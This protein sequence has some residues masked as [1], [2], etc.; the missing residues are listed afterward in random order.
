MKNIIIGITVAT[1][2]LG[3]CNSSSNKTGDNKVSTDTTKTQQQTDS[4][5]TKDT[6]S[7]K[8]I[9]SGYMQLK[10]ALAN[11]NGND[12]ANGGKAILDAVAK[13]D[14]SSLS[15]QQKKVYEDV[16]DDIKDNPEHIRENSGKIAHQRQHFDMLSQDMYDLVKA[17]GTGQILYNDYCAMYNNA[18]GAT[19]LSETKEIKN[20]YLG[21]KMPTCGE[22]KE[23]IK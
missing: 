5:Q 20:P 11:D 19:W 8:E 2:S 12:A 7:I 9:I 21:K 23:E 6:V 13:F 17:F 1:I 22:V 14:I 3:G 15:A 16:A 4:T 18:K 10:N